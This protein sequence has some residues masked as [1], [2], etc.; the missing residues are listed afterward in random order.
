MKNNTKTMIKNT[1]KQTNKKA[2]VDLSFKQEKLN[3]KEPN[4]I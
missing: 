1:Q 3:K 2:L 4:V